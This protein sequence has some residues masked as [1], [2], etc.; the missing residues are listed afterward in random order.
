MTPEA[1]APVQSNPIP[2]ASETSDLNVIYSDPLP[3]KPGWRTSEF[4]SKC[5]VQL[6]AL[7]VL[8]G[9]I[10]ARYAEHAQELALALIT[11]VECAYAISRGMA[12]QPAV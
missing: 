9:I 10:P 12:K 7:A 11:I 1:T 8:T 6:I 5:V 3:I 2:T 4:R